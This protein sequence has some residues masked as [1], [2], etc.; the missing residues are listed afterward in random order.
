M[1]G[2]VRVGFHRFE[3]YARHPG[4]DGA[5]LAYSE[6][7]RLLAESPEV[8]PVPHDLLQL[9]ADDQTARAALGRCDVVVS[10]VGPHAYLYF[11]LRERLGLGFRIVRDV[12]TALWNGYLLQEVL[13]APYLRPSD[14]LVHSSAYSR[15]LFS[16]LLRHLPPEGQHVCYPLLHWFPRGAAGTWRGSGARG[17]RVVGFV[18]R[19]TEDKNFPQALELLAELRRRRPGAYE[20]R[21]VGEGNWPL[22]RASVVLRHLGGDLAGYS[23]T[24]PLWRKLLW[25]C[26]AGMDVLFFPSTSTLETFGRVLAEGMH[27]GVPVLA[28]DHAAA[29]E[30]LEPDALLETTYRTGV[31]FSAQ[32][33]APLGTIDIRAAA[34]RLLDGAPL[35]R[36]AGH[37]AYAGD[38]V[39]FLELV[40]QGTPARSVLPKPGQAAFIG[41]IRVQG[42]VPATREQ[43]DAAILE[44]RPRFVALHRRGH[45]AYARALLELLIRSSDRVKTLRFIRRSLLRGED[46]TNIGGI[47]LQFSHLLRF[48]PTFT[49]APAAQ[50]GCTRSAGTVP[51]ESLLYEA[52]HR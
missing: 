43:A 28:S 14:A 47:D 35:P 38:P 51:E 22:G 20:L 39:R 27:V 3:T 32:R 17:P 18:G 30:L 45:S 15:A 49:L 25:D 24:P 5:N 21:V 52:S 46:F 48:Y 26:Y 8:E 42:L 23:W 44:L 50:A 34:E 36:S 11:Y 7:W 2:R 37:L 4:F 41:R 12:R 16:R 6:L 33:A 10:T 19:L 40:T 13:S 9:C 31:E 29:P 1:C